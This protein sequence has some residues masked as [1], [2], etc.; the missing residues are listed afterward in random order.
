M[1][2]D[3]EHLLDAWILVQEHVIQ[4]LSRVLAVLLVHV[5]LYKDKVL[6]CLESVPLDTSIMPV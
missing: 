6:V 2:L 1:E 5:V 4:G 3:A